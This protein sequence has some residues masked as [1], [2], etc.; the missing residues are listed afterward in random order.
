MNRIFQFV[1]AL[2]LACPLA[3]HAGEYR[4]QLSVTKPAVVKPGQT[5][6]IS[7]TLTGWFFVKWI[8]PA[9]SGQGSYIVLYRG[10]TEIARYRISENNTAVT[11]TVSK[12]GPSG[13]N[14]LIGL[15]SETTARFTVT[16][17]P[18]VGSEVYS[19]RY[20]GEYWSD[21]AESGPFTIRY[22]NGG[23]DSAV[24]T[25]LLTD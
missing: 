20:L 22:G 4:T 10:P 5:F 8:Y 12:P 7:A 15:G 16:A 2:A 13:W 11:R 9:A 24:T 1:L 19:V 18:Q 6:Q 14:D 21:A 3:G 25:L 23:A 17:P